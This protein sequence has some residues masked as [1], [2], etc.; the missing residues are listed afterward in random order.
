MSERTPVT[1][2]VDYGMGNLRSVAKAIEHLG[3]RPLVTSD[4]ADLG[5]ADRVI[6]PGVGAFGDC[7]LALEERGLRDA[8]LQAA[9]SKPFLGICLGMQVL[10]ESSEEHGLHQGLGL[11]PGRVLAFPKEALVDPQGRALKIPHM[12][13]NEVHQLA[14]HPLWSSIPQDARFYFVHSYYVE[15]ADPELLAAFTPYA[16]PFASVVAH[17]N[18]FAVQF[19]PEKSQRAGLTLLGNF[20]NWN[21]ETTG[22]SCGQ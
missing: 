17:E 11:L 5:R 20:L 4:P 9:R 22:G 15:P 3:G 1:A 21:G 14:P 13:W 7:L 16:F 10:M 19:H 6:F 18:I 2:I 8:L 12:G